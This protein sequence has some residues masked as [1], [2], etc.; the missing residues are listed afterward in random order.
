M[1]A[2]IECLNRPS[3][4]GTKL[5]AITS[6]RPASRAP[7]SARPLP[8]A[9]KFIIVNAEFLVFVIHN[10]SFLIQNSSFLIHNT[11]S[12]IYNVIHNSSVLP[13]NPSDVGYPAISVTSI[14]CMPA[15]CNSN[16]P[17]RR[18]PGAYFTFKLPSMFY[19]KCEKNVEL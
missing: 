16:P 1:N 6:A 5:D 18:T 2:L 15:A 17:V 8:S 19:W 11:S 14:T 9:A 4:F 10:L 12:L 13:T 3:Y 7:L